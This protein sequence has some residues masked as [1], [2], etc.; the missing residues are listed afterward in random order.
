[1]TRGLLELLSSYILFL[2]SDR[3]DFDYI[4]SLRATKLDKIDILK[5]TSKCR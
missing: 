2:H 4:G 1:M 5:K 3:L